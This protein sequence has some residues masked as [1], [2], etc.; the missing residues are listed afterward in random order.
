MRA[1]RFQ[2]AERVVGGRAL[3]FVAAL[4]LALIQA[5]PEAR[6]Q[7][8]CGNPPCV[9]A[10]TTAAGNVASSNAVFDMVTIFL[11]HQSR[12]MAASR[13]AF[14]PAAPSGVALAFGEASS[15]DPLA[16][17]AAN[18]TKAAATARAPPRYRAWIEGYDSIA[19]T[20]AQGAFTGDRRNA[21]G[22]I[23][24]FGATLAP[25]VNFGLTVDQGHTRVDVTSLPQR[26]AMD[27]TQLGAMLSLDSGPWTLGV[28]GIYGFGNIRASRLETAG[29]A[30]ASYGTKMWGAIVEASYYWSSGGFRVVP[31]A[32]FDFTHVSVDSYR[33]SGGT[34]PVVG[35]AQTTDR[36]RV[37][38]ALELGR[39][40]QAASAIYDFSIY[41]KLIDIVSQR[42][43][44]V[45]ATPVVGG[46]FTPVTIPSVVDAR[47]EYATGASF[48]VR[49]SSLTRVYVNYDG[50]FRDGYDAHGGAAGLE[51]RF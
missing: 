30:V 49:F 48:T 1:R 17:Y 19:R 50:R 26:S 24:G 39:T 37:Y 28:A 43:T 6:A 36:G 34:V 46:V 29:E 21:Y 11:N 4:G 2:F 12:Q 3:A 8:V 7:Q 47:V 20:G 41:G 31:K 51:V 35:S 25:G 5:A 9:L 33:E 15:N 42:V 40:T 13:A 38:G 16:A 22:G 10:N 23:A 27:V 45:T 14:T 44:P 32:G 18:V